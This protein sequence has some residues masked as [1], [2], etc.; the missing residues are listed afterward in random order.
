[1]STDSSNIK[2]SNN[3]IRDL[4]IARLS[5]LSPDAYLSIGSDGSFSRDDLMKH[6]SDGDEIGRKIEAIEMEWVR[7]W[8][9]RASVA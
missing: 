8:K 1:M 2:Q 5:V 6:V 3:D 4:V 9:N 7:S